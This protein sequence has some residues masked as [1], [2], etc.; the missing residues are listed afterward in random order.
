MTEW[1]DTL[2]CKGCGVEIVGPPVLVGKQVYCC[3]DCSQGLEC[4]CRSWG[5]Q[6]EDRAG[7]TPPSTGEVEN[8]V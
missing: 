4:S 6:E 2:W 1:K 8:L 7:R 3:Q 5:E